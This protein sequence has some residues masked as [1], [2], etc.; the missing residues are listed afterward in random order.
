MATSCHRLIEAPHAFIFGDTAQNLSN[1][2]S[3][4]LKVG[5]FFHL[6]SGYVKIAIENTPFI[7]DLPIQNG[8]FL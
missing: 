2:S 6:P 4:S 5:I 3:P 7:I 1:H 8:D